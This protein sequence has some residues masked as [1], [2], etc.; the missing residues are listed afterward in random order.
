M[1]FYALPQKMYTMEGITQIL[2]YKEN[3]ILYKRLQEDVIDVEALMASHVIVYIVEGR[4]QV[5]TYEG[6]EL[7][8]QKGDMLFMPRDSYV[9]SDYVVGEKDVEV[10]LLFFNDE[11]AQKLLGTYKHVKPS[12]AVLCPLKT[13]ENIVSY[14]RDIETLKISDIHNKELLKSK[15]L[16]FLYLVMQ[17]DKEL[18]LSTLYASK[19]QKQERDIAAFM[20]IHFDKKLSVEDYASLSGRSLSTFT[21]AFKRKYNQTPKQWIIRKRVEKSQQLLEKG[22]S[23][24]DVAFEVG[25]QNVSHFIRA[26]QSIYHQTPK[27]MQQKL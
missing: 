23:V 4:A 12:N 9:I 21:R 27:K 19:R 20:D 22:M 14:L 10:F 16:E 15:L 11:I 2:S 3:A 8:M 5:N 7:H 6:E 17:E 25:Y 13:S 18:F 24:T 1:K 26:Y